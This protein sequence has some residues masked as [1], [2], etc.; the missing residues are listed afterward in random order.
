[1]IDIGKGA[2]QDDFIW[3]EQILRVRMESYFK[4]KEDSIYN[5]VPSLPSEDSLYARIVKGY[6]MTTAERIVLLLALAP[7][8]VPQILDVFFIKKKKNARSFF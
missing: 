4:I 1:M 2:L 5:Y 8:I 6:N 3:L 7:H